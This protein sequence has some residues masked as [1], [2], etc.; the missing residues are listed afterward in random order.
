[1]HLIELLSF[2]RK[3]LSVSENFL[4]IRL[5][6]GVSDPADVILGVTSF[7][8]RFHRQWFRGRQ[9]LGA[10]HPQA[11]ERPQPRNHVQP[12]RE[13]AQHDVGL[14]LGVRPRVNHSV[15]RLAQ[16]AKRHHVFNLN[17]NQ[18]FSILV[19]GGA[20]TLRAPCS[21]TQNEGVRPSSHEELSSSESG[22]SI[23]IPI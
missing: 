22:N 10:W 2:V 16:N 1:M 19:F 12:R 18:Y 3:F 11:I 14:F 15:P 20:Y 21:R 5:Q 17:T 4:D 13:N 8:R 9:L 7:L 6:S 23:L